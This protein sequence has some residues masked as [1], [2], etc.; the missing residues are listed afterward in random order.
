MSLKFISNEQLFK[1]AIEP[2]AKA[3]SFVWIG[4]ADIKDM[5]IPFG[6]RVTSFLS[7]L[8]DLCKK[9]VEIRLL[10]AKEPGPHFRNS[11]DKYPLLLERLERQL[12]PRVHFKLIIIDGK[13]AYTGSANLTGAGLGI[14][15]KN[16]R[17]FESGIIT[18]DPALVEQIMKQFDEVWMGKH[19]RSCQRKQYCGDPIK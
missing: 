6:G 10:H 17:N 19:C 13:L 5:H 16:T 11:Y 2:I 8:N 4:T 7:L 15:G 14:K 18:S 1:E 3:K 9:R 12:C